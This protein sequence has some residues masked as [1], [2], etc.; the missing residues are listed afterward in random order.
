MD[1][2]IKIN[3][4]VWNHVPLDTRDLRS[5]VFQILFEINISK[6]KLL[7][8]ECYHQYNA[9]YSRH[10]AGNTQNGASSSQEMESDWKLKKLPHNPM[11][12]IWEDRCAQLKV[13]VES[14]FE[15]L[16]S[17]YINESSLFCVKAWKG[18]VII[19]SLGHRSTS[20]FDDNKLFVSLFAASQKCDKST[21]IDDV[22]W[23][24][25]ERK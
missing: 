23:P 10:I 19:S 22:I 4:V 14:Y 20:K 21:H 13:I 7:L 25:H 8:T 16:Q 2:Q 11:P 1:I 9:L 15:K 24:N 17:N 6:Q 12:N 3:F 18:C 5:S